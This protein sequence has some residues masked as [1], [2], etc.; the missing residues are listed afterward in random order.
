VARQRFQSYADYLAQERQR[1]AIA[2][3]DFAAGGEEW[4]KERYDTLCKDWHAEFAGHVEEREPSRARSKRT[5]VHHT[6]RVPRA[7]LL[8]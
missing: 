1:D 7:V 3:S 8:G 4:T 6:R 5:L 2:L